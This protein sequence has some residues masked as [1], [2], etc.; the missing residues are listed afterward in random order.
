VAKLGTI[1]AEDSELGSTGVTAIGDSKTWI[2]EKNIPIF[3]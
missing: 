2:V 1:I 3:I